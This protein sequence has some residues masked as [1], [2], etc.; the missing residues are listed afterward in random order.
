VNREDAD[1]EIWFGP[2]GYQRLLFRLSHTCPL[3]IAMDFGT[4]PNSIKSSCTARENGL[5]PFARVRGR[6][7]LMSP[8]GDGLSY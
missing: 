8:V 2:I 5:F 4:L 3:A 1:V 7:S 6:C